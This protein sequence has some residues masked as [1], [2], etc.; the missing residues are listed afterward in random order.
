MVKIGVYLKRVKRLISLT[1]SEKLLSGANN[2]DI[3]EDEVKKQFYNLDMITASAIA[4]MLSDTKAKTASPFISDLKKPEITSLLL[5]FCKDTY[6]ATDIEQLN[7]LFNKSYYRRKINRYLAKVTLF[8]K[9]GISYS[10]VKKRTLLL[11]RNLRRARIQKNIHINKICETI[12]TYEAVKY[13][14]AL[15]AN[16]EISDSK[17]SYKL[18]H[19]SENYRDALIFLVDILLS[20][21]CISK[22]LFVERMIKKMNPDSEFNKIIANMALSID[23]H[24]II[25]NK[26]RPIYKQYYQAELGYINGDD[27]LYG[28]AITIMVNK[29]RKVKMGD[30]SGLVPDYV[31]QDIQSFNENMLDWL[32]GLAKDGMVADIGASILQRT[33]LSIKNNYNLLI[34][35]LGE[36]TSWEE[37]YSYKVGYYKMERNRVR[38][39]KGDFDLEKE[40]VK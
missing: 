2:R 4:I 14:P 37:Y 31:P 7:K 32:D 28:M 36:L 22:M 11:F 35:A 18:D 24:D 34:C 9:R 1:A 21:T 20:C 12:N 29:A 40:E 25:I 5:R 10:Q 19:L 13:I 26:S 8:V 33:T 15:S 16:E 6:F 27:L 3:S 30:I 38:Y 39:L 23:S 17:M